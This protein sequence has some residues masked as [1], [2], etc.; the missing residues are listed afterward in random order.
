VF[1]QLTSV[2]VLSW[3]VGWREQRTSHSHRLFSC[4]VLLLS[5]VS[6]LFCSDLH[7]ACA[8]LVFWGVNNRDFGSSQSAG[9]LLLDVRFFPN[10]MSKVHP[11]HFF[12][13]S[14]LPRQMSW[15][16][17]FSAGVRSWTG[18]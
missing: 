7:G 12:N 4:F 11:L 16:V 17:H 10:T 9:E 5:A 15:F 3:Q 18:L 2:V 6:V 14:A 13:F 1:E 8:E